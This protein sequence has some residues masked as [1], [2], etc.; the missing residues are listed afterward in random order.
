MQI[1]TS[2]LSGR[3]VIAVDNISYAW[4]DVPVVSG[5]TTQIMRGDKVGIIGP[6]GCGKTT[7]LKLLL[8]HL[9]PQKGSV[10]HGTNIE[11]AYFD[12]HRERLDDTRSVAENACGE[13]D[14]VTFNGKR[15]H[16]MS[17]LEDFLFAPERSRSPVRAL[18][19]GERN[20][21][22][23]ARLFTR[24]F[25]MLVMDEPTNDLDAETLELLEDLLVEHEGTLLLV[26]HDRA[27][28][29]NVVTSTLVFEGNGRIAEYVGGYDDWLRQRAIP[30]EHNGSAATATTTAPAPPEKPR[31]LSMKERKELEEW[32]VRIESMEAEIRELE[33]SLADPSF[34]M[35]LVDDVRRV[36]DRLATLNED[37]ERA[38]NR[39]AEL[40][41]R[42]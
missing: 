3:K 6:N 9:A 11:I 27:F 35:R 8:G 13:S 30:A 5:L 23:L 41:A 12:Q 34:F 1:Q 19:G 22:L 37:L 32:P 40:E 25:N 36:T 26:S 24:P 21:L 28:I 39:W 18:S 17:Y 7:L 20:R 10:E 33:T 29:N 31:K 2:T 42:S 14:Y 38:I 4:G 16:I 15:R